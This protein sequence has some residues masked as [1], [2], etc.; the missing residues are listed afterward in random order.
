MICGAALLSFAHG[1]NDVANA[2][3]P[4]AAIHSAVAGGV[5]H[6]TDTV[7][8]DRFTHVPELARLG[9]KI[10]LNAEGQMV[11]DTGILYEWPKGQ[12]SEF[13]DAGSH[14]QV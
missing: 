12:R 1:A 8:L 6:I 2:V 4:L 14:L 11:V 13:N 9:A 10:E 3:G 5:S 7:Y